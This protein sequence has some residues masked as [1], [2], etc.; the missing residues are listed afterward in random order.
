MTPA[1]LRSPRAIG[2]KLM[3]TRVD[4]SHVTGAS[5]RSY[6]APRPDGRSDAE[7]HRESGG[8]VEAKLRMGVRR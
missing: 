4:V 1:V 7:R 5:I 6:Y 3:R 2:F 8:D